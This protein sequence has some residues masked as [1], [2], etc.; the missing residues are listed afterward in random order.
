[1]AWS[2]STVRPSIHCGPGHPAPRSPIRLPQR[3]P[4]RRRPPAA[5]RSRRSRRRV[6][7][8]GS[9][10][11]HRAAVVHRRQDR[12]RC[13]SPLLPAC[14]GGRQPA[15]ILRTERAAFV[16]S[17]DTISS[18]YLAYQFFGPAHDDCQA[19]RLMARGWSSPGSPSRSKRG[20]S[21]QRRH[22]CAP[23]ASRRQPICVG[24]GLH[25][26]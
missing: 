22:R 18:T 12:P 23:W 4:G 3:L 13:R 19:G 9:G 17:P 15:E 24:P 21:T 8:R 26:E 25:G 16:D 14:P 1:M 5:R 2:S 10:R 11:R 6:P 20:S 7:L